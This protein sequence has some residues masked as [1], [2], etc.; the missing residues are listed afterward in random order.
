MATG[1]GARAVLAARVRGLP[2][3]TQVR[4]A[5]LAGLTQETVSRWKKGTG[6]PRLSQLETFAE[7]MGVSVRWLITMD[8]PD[9]KPRLPATTAEERKAER[10][11]RDGERIERELRPALD[12]LR[13][14]R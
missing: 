2:R 13:S 9:E 7:A 14:R 10:L 8:G 5:H 11:I 12:R 6:N 1:R 3:G 4:L